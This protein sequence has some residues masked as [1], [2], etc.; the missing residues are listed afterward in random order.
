VRPLA[1]PAILVSFVGA[2]LATLV[3][4]LVSGR[5]ASAAE[6][7]SAWPRAVAH[8]GRIEGDHVLWNSSFV[9]NDTTDSS[10]GV[11]RIELARPVVADLDAE[12][13]PG[14]S[15]V[16]DPTGAIVA[17]AVDTRQIDGWREGVQVS[18]RAPLKTEGVD[19]VLVPPLARGGAIQRIEV[20]GAGETRLEPDPSLGLVHDVG[21]WTTPGI[22]E[23][24][25]RES[26]AL[27]GRRNAPLDE[28]P[29]YVEAASPSLDRGLRGRALTQEER[30][31]PG[32][33]IAIGIFILLAA[34][35]A[36]A[37]RWLAGDARIEEAEATLRE[38]YAREPRRGG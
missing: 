9:G 1:R 10:S 17:F 11:V 32:K 26:D 35:C 34:A 24:A 13:S 28:A 33:L 5:V 29:I 2:A 7:G 4:A 22:S 30:A 14:V 12:H 31:R 25:R 37:Y 19:V 16:H 18:L 15:T 21:S 6:T 20:S 27:L 8:V 38:E 23:W 36:G 3:L